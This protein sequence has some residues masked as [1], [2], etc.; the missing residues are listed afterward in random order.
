MK[1]QGSAILIAVLLVTAIGSLAFSF[2]RILLADIT[3]ANIYENGAGAYYSAESGVEEGMLR[4]RFAPTATVPASNWNLGASDWVYRSDLAAKTAETGLDVGIDRN[5]AI[6]AN[7]NQTYDLRLGYIG[8]GATQPF[9]GED[10]DANGLD[11]SDLASDKYGATIPSLRVPKDEVLKISLPA[12]FNLSGPNGA[13]NLL[14]VFEN[15]TDPAGTVDKDKAVIEV[16]AIAKRPTNLNRTYEYKK[17]VAFSSPDAISNIGGSDDDYIPRNTPWDSVN[18]KKG[19]AINN[20][21]GGLGVAYDPPVSGTGGTEIE[22]SFRPLFNNIRI[23]LSTQGCQNY[24]GTPL[25]ACDG[26]TATVMPGPVARIISSGH[27]AD[28]IKTLEVN[29]DRQSGTLYDLYDNVVYSANNGTTYSLTFQNSGDCVAKITIG[30]KDYLIPASTGSGPGSVAVSYGKNSNL[31][32]SL[33]GVNTPTSV[34]L[35]DSTIH[36]MQDITDGWSSPTLVGGTYLLDRNRTISA[37][38]YIPK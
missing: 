10:L 16:K 21:L 28:V 35:A 25:A 18:G 32:I 30:A 11:I 31:N 14:V 1:K 23:G 34:C 17:M 15:P 37:S 4:Y 38:T 12:K 36:P 5:T 33:T 2:G 27:Y 3:G 9:W 22:L 26:T 24:I 13:L 19:L 8:S 20:L 7:A 29:V 6:T